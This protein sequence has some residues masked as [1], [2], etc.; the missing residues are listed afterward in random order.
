MGGRRVGVLVAVGAFVLVGC[1]SPS[2]SP[3]DFT[4]PEVS[5]PPEWT[6]TTSTSAPP[7]TTT[8]MPDGVAIAPGDSLSDASAAAEE[9][10]TFILEPGVH[11]MQTLDP[12]AEQRFLGMEG[13][14]LSGAMLLTEFEAGDGY[15]THGGIDAQG[16]ERGTCV[17]EESTCTLPEDLYV[18]DERLRRV[19]SLGEVEAG[20]WFLDHDSDTLYL[21]SDPTGREVELA[22]LPYAFGGKSQDVTIDGLIIEKYASPAQ[23]GAVMA[24]TGW[25]IVNNELR[26]NHGAGLYVGS[27]L[28]VANNY[29]HHNGQLGI[30][31]GG[32]NSVYEA[33][34][35]AYNHLGDFSFQWGAG[36]MKFVHTHGMVLRENFVH[37]NAGPGIWIDGFN[38]D[39]TFEGNRIVDN[40]DSG[41]KVE[42]SGSAVIADNVVTGNAFGN[43]D[44]LRGAGIM[45][46][47]SGPVEVYGN[48]VAGNKEALILFHDANRNNPTENFLHDIWVHDNEIVL[49][50]HV[51]FF[52][53]IGSD[54][55]LRFENNVY[56]GSGDETFF[57]DGGD[58]IT[59]QEWQERG[60][61]PGGSLLDG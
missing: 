15:W 32:V 48:R 6:Q 41:I 31:E 46:R 7:A 4:R 1:S 42:I 19:A 2:G 56:R 33:N 57:L 20:S 29:I 61:D 43:P 14:V 22:V 40:L 38:V 11:R 28:Y 50:G 58:T 27:E 23:R 36:G 51:G 9:G 60:H 21:G 30:A 12:R 8:T 17:N 26:W 13:A 47:E 3:A 39:T 16:E 5:I 54:A 52:G 44:N 35:V 10:E 37:H 24:A 53:D 18:D 45:I 55:D 34:E 49:D 59:F 25:T